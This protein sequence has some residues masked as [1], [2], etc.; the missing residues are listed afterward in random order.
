VEGD[1]LADDHF[2]RTHSIESTEALG[3]HGVANPYSCLP[4][5]DKI[6]KNQ[7]LFQDQVSFDIYSEPTIYPDYD[8]K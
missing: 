2:G 3:L 6:K 4:G 8:G 7:N 5:G 1:N